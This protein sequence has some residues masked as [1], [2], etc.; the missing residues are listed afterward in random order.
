VTG[1]STATP[2][3]I[4]GYSS[5][6]YPSTCYNPNGNLKG[7]CKKNAQYGVG[8][9]YGPGPKKAACVFER[10]GVNEFT[11]TSPGGAGVAPA[12]IAMI[13]WNGTTGSCGEETPIQPLTKNKDTLKSAIDGMVANNG[14]AGALG[15]AWA[16]YLLSPQWSNIFT[17][18]A[19]PA[20]YSQLT[21]L[22][23]ENK[24]KLRKIA[25]LMTDGAYNNY[26]SS[27]YNVTTV[28]DKAV[29]LC[30]AMKA[31]GIQVYTIGFQVGSNATAVKTLTD[32]ASSHVIDTGASIKNFYNTETALGLQAAFRDI[33]LQISKLRLVR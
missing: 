14:T 10:T 8:P 32:C 26:Q 17:G 33:A 4:T 11:E 27:D 21:E 18:E 19:A 20:S 9:I 24:P 16:W 23:A 25:I 13:P 15:T 12:N 1:Q 22:N 6:S 3:V 5:Y 31:K 7:S 29:S 2:Q 30:S 28:S